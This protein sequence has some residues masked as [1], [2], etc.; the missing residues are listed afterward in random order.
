LQ[1]VQ[2]QE[3]RMKAENKKQKTT[4]K[5]KPTAKL[6]LQSKQWFMFINENC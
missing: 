2:G 3:I 6:A 1:G 4:A 5:S